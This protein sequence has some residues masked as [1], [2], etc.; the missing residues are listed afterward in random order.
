MSIP[1]W[2]HTLIAKEKVKH[3][4][5]CINLKHTI[6]CLMHV[7]IRVTTNQSGYKYVHQLLQRV[8]NQHTPPQITQ[9]N[10]WHHR[11]VYLLFFSDYYFLSSFTPYNNFV[12][13]SQALHILSFLKSLSSIT[14]NE[15]SPICLSC[16]TS[17]I[18]VVSR[19]WLWPH[20]IILLRY[21]F[22]VIS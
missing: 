16:S 7:N 18:W 9:S 19:L 8:S 14:L 1:N 3:R 20:L 11:L 13:I 10:F 17:N 2:T 4:Q 15:N 5:T 21:I 6:Q 12:F 22:N